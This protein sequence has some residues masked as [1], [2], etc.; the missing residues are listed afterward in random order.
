MAD[1][2]AQLTLA[3]PVGLPATGVDAAAFFA[4]LA[5]RIE[6]QV[7]A[8]VVSVWTDA[9]AVYSGLYP[10]VKAAVWYAPVGA[11]GLDGGPVSSPTLYCRTWP[12]EY[13]SLRASTGGGDTALPAVIGYGNVDPDEVELAIAS[14]LASNEQYANLSDADRT[15][16][17]SDFMAGNARLLVEAGHR[18]GMGQVDSSRADG[19]RRV[20]VTLSGSTDLP[21]PPAFYWS[22]WATVGGELVTGHPL[23]AL[24]QG[25]V[26][27]AMAPIEGGIRVKLSGTGLTNTTPVSFGGVAAT[28]ARASADGTAI[29]VDAPAGA[30]G[31]VD[32]VVGTTTYSAAFA[33]T[34]DVV[35]T[36]QAALTSHLLYLGELAALASAGPLDDDT[37]L[38]LKIEAD[39]AGVTAGGAI[40]HRSSAIGAP[41]IDP[42]VADLIAAGLPTLTSLDAA[43]RAA[44]G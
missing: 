35:A 14:E 7:S 32:V 31:T 41:A 38:K 4:D 44:L 5:G 26:S 15:T 22:L 27:P 36:A 6:A 33:Y 8:T 28:A 13:L 37:W 1:A 2:D 39:H 11:A 40:E 18:I 20:D 42:A 10:M 21:L 43:V 3:M 17:V 19:D 24:V 12:L 34:E 30:A 23:I 16:I 9:D 25:P 29:Y